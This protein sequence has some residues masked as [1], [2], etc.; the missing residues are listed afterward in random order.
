MYSAAR[1]GQ[2]L[3]R[4]VFVNALLLAAACSGAALLPTS[5]QAAEGAQPAILAL[6]PAERMSAVVAGGS[7]ASD[8]DMQQVPQPQPLP[9][10]TD[11][12]PVALPPVIP[13]T[14]GV[15]PQGEPIKA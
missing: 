4:S 5:V 9:P 2:A 3:I 13:A 6:A 1:Y 14:T 12:V 11:G 8:I 10:G 7:P 15:C